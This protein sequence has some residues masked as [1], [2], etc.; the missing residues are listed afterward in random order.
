[1]LFVGNYLQ[2]KD[3]KLF[4]NIIKEL[5]KKE[6][7]KAKMVGFGELEEEI[8]NEIKK[9]SL[10]KIITMIKPMPNG[11]LKKLY[12]EADVFVLT[13]ISEGQ[14]LVILEAMA[15]KTAVVTTPAGGAREIIQNG[16]NGYITKNRNPKDIAELIILAKKNK[17]RIGKA[18]QKTIKENFQWGIITKEYLKLYQRILQARGLKLE[19]QS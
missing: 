2:V 9:Y 16:K 5:S 4:I 3:P 14:G 17:K 10:E 13:S 15:T 12:D 1:V 6:S 18:A 19:K 7:V 11:K 8:K